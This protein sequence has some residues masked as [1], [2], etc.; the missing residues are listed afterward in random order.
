MDIEK[1]HKHFPPPKKK[2]ENKV[3]TNGTKEV[4]PLTQDCTEN[5][6]ISACSAISQF[7]LKKSAI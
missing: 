5:Y 1:K 3:E 4:C 7:H 2:K 6:L